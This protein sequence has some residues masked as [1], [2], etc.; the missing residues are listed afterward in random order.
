MTSRLLKGAAVAM[1]LGAAI[2]CDAHDND[3]DVPRSNA[4]IVD[5][6]EREVDCEATPDKPACRHNAAE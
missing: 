2:G 6:P 3:R 4:V 1:F 5:E